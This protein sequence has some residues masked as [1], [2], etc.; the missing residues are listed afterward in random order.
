M[1]YRFLPEAE[2]EYAEAFDYYL[3]IE[4]NLAG[5]FVAEVETAMAHIRRYPFLRRVVGQ[6]IRR[7]LLATFPFGIYYVCENDRIAIVAIM[8]QSRNPARWKKRQP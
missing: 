6:T 2:K 4:A 3:A 7:H 8:H 1:N 5:R